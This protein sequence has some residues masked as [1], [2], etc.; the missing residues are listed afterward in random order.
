[1]MPKL[2]LAALCLFLAGCVT[3]SAPDKISYLQRQKIALPEAQKF[4]HCRGYGCKFKDKAEFTPEEWYGIA[5][6]FKSKRATAADER[7]QISTAIGVME[8]MAGKKLGT[9]EDVGG[10][11]AKLGN[12]QLDCVDESTNTTSYLML[13]KQSGFLKHHTIGAPEVRLP[14]IDSGLWP[15][16]TAVIVEIESGTAYAVDSWF[17]DNGTPADVVTVVEWKDGWSPPAE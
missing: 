9:A 4:E 16:Q 10:T 13:L 5:A 17:R 15:H 6:L 12:Y 2:W 8:T 3:T 7:K 1:M 14:I 11:F